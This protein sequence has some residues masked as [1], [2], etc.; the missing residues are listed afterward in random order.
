MFKL[1]NGAKPQHPEPTILRRRK[2]E[3]QQIVKGILEP[4]NNP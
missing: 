1:L 4:E 2:R 3:N